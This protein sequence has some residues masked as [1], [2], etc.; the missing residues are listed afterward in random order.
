MAAVPSPPPLQGP[1]RLAC[2][3]SI[4]LVFVCSSIQAQCVS[5]QCEPDFGGQAPHQAHAVPGDDV[6]KFDLDGSGD[7]PVDLDGGLSHS[8]YF[9]A[10]PPIVNGEIV[11]YEW[12]T[13]KGDVVCEKVACKGVVFP[14]GETK[15][16]LTVKDQTGDVANDEIVITIK[17]GDQATGK[18][19]IS[20]VEP[21]SGGAAG[22]TKVTLNGKN[23][24]GDSSVTV[25]GKAASNVNVVNTGLI[26]FTTPSGTPGDVEVV[27]S[28]KQGS[29]GPQTF[30][31]SGGG[32]AVSVKFYKDTWK[33]KDGSVWKQAQEVTG[34]ALLDGV[35]YLSTLDG[36]VWKVVVD[37]GLTVQS[38]CSGA[39]A[40][41]GRS[42]F[43]IAANP[44]D[45]SK[46]L[47]V[48]SNT[49]FWKGKGA[50]WKNGK[51]EFVNVDGAG[52]CVSVGDTI[53]SGLPVSN[54]DHGVSKAAFSPDGTMY[55]TVGGATNAGIVSDSLG[56]IA[57]SPLS[58][59]VLEIPY[60]KGGFNG[61]VK[62]TSDD[63]A[64]TNVASGD[65]SVYA[66][67]FR[68]SFGILRH[69]NG[70]IYVT[71]NGP[72]ANFG[73]KSTGCNSEGPDANTQDTLHKT[74]RGSWHGHP[75]RNRGRTDPK[76]C[77]YR[78]PGW[79]N[80]IAWMPSSTN[81]IVEYKSNIFG[82]QA[83]GDIFLT[84]LAWRGLPGKVSR[85]EIDGN[86]FATSTAYEVYG[87]S[88]NSVIETPNGALCMPQLKNYVVLCLVPDVSGNSARFAMPGDMPESARGPEVHHVYPRSGHWHGG[89][90]VRV[91]GR[92]FS[93]ESIVR[94]GNQECESTIYESETS[95]ICQ[96]PPGHPGTSAAVSVTRDGVTSRT[97]G[98]DYEWFGSRN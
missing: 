19:S 73:K 45:K 55:L 85:V 78:G 66:A 30:S 22:G 41:P 70:I 74:F 35:Y 13:Q 12:K 71:D 97:Y 1:K 33:N 8:H 88:G 50:D 23:F 54:H 75:N 15:V 81:G 93:P 63:P 77:V 48:T 18:P 11:S 36:K 65:V 49:M 83:K 2:L 96:V 61:Q 60:L 59:A 53:V 14:V 80:A 32:G 92:N 31:Y 51:V 5:A 56:G 46:R 91:V 47:V 52:G 21:K 16:T 62:Y 89:Q 20:S 87:Q 3:V 68:N 24:F 7:E 25:G 40:G 84:K 9:Q 76:Q 44:A 29:S 10:G 94:V 34:I 79:T 90:D 64:S 37:D 6:S 26:T 43:G 57:E 67:G 27:V 86:G 82:G 38:A 58:A 39:Q 28:T 69:S 42:Y 72:N 95:I 4:V 98:P 17:P